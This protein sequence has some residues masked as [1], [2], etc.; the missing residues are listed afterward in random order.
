MLNV[1]EFIATLSATLFCGAAIYINLAEL[2]AGNAHASVLGHC[3]TSG[4]RRS[5]VAR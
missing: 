2:Q 5:M 3:R 4:R 1:L